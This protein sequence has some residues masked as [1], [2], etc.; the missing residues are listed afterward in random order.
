MGRI[1]DMF[2]RVG[3]AICAGTFL[4]ASCAIAVQ[5]LEI[6]EAFTVD[7]DADDQVVVPHQHLL[8]LGDNFLNGGD[9]ELT[10]G[11]FPLTVISQSDTEIV[12]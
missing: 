8:L 5:P 6:N 11:G 7:A 9:I 3:A 4:W 12:A 10:L 2:R 1:M